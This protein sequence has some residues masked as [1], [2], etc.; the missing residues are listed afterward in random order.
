MTYVHFSKVINASAEAV[1]DV[2]GDFGS[3]PQWFP[4]VESSTLTGG[5]QTIGTVR[6]NTVT[7]GNVIEERL[8]ELSERDKRVVY[9]VVGGDVPTTDYTAELTVYPVSDSDRCFVH[10]SATFDVEG[11]IAPAADWVRNGIF[12][13]CLTELERILTE[14]KAA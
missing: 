4:F 2:V 1:W 7:G 13:T 6:A 14:Q 8:I 10:W 3:L 12:A 9:S 5:A 11:E